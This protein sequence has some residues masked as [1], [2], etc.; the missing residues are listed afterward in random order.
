[1]GGNREGLETP[2]GPDSDEGLTA[3]TAIQDN[4]SGHL[5][6]AWA[7]AYDRHPDAS[8]AWDNAIKA[9]E[10]TLRKSISPD[11]KRATLGTLIRDLRDGAHKFQLVLTNEQGGVRTLLAMLQ[12]MWPNPDRHEGPNSR[13]PTIEEARAVVQLAVT[14]VQW[15]RDDQIVRR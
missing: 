11:N 8:H 13:T 2:S 5:A 3:A 1:L 6:A 15:A 10:A 12:L 7:K 4:A 9:V 14:I